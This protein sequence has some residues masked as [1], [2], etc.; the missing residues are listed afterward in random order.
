[1]NNDV[2]F[3]IFT[4]LDYKT[5][6]NCS[7]CCKKFYNISRNNLLWKKI[8][9]KKFNIDININCLEEFK[10]NLK[11]ETHLIVYAYYLNFLMITE[12]MTGLMYSD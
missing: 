12:G 4:H 10:E 11:K 7:L 1:M 6:I 3:E 9:K 2:I 5:I 8:L